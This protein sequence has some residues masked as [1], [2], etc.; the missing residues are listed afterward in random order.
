M[1]TDTE[2]H[3]LLAPTATNMERVRGLLAL[4]LPASAVAAATRSSP[5]TLRNW[6]VGET[7]PREEASI[8]LD[9]LRTTAKVLLDAGLEPERVVRWLLS[10][11]PGRFGGMR[12]IDMITYDPMDVVA[13]AHE[14]VL[15]GGR[16]GGGNGEVTPLPLPRRS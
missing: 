9:D 2:L 7:K 15:P 10:R 3:E 16:N 13:A 11:D 5:S 14:S 4:G 12:P 1:D 8:I 6:S